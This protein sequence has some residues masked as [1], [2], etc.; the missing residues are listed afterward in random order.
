MNKNYLIGSAF[1]AGALLLSIILFFTL[2]SDSAEPQKMKPLTTNSQPPSANDNIEPSKN[3]NKKPVEA[4]LAKVDVAEPKTEE[5]KSAESPVPIG[6]ATIVQ[7]VEIKEPNQAPLISSNK[8]EIEAAN[9][10]KITADHLP[11]QEKKDLVEE[12]K[13]GEDTPK[14]ST[15]VVK[16][17]VK[18]APTVA[19]LKKDAPMAVES[20][21]GSNTFGKDALT[22]TESTLTATAS[23]P[24]TGTSFI[25]QIISSTGKSKASSSTKS[26]TDIKNHKKTVVDKK[27]V[28][29]KP[30]KKVAKNGEVVSVDFLSLSEDDED[31]KPTLI[32]IKKTSKKRTSSKKQTNQTKNKKTKSPKKSATASKVN[33]LLLNV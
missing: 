29:P 14:E 17:E 10:S 20:T 33:S 21:F 15:T 25:S 19:E 26:V 1:A 3:D 18:D 31:S 28:A 4:S 2:R 12:I 24:P 13:T 23:A 5:D 7:N 32:N 6:S 22:P 8:P 30:K 9:V 11:N 27:P 16:V